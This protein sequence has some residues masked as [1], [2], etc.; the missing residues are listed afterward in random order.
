VTRTSAWPIAGIAFHVLNG[1]LFGIAF[2]EVRQAHVAAF[3]VG[4]RL[5][6]RSRSIWRSSH[7]RI[8]STAR[9]RLAA[10][11]ASVSSSTGAGSR[12]QRRR[13]A[14]FGIVLGRLASERG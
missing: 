6:L 14:L 13:H 10:G 11:R 1:A 9:T 7:S 5:D 4:L 12:R 3:A 8:S 2:D